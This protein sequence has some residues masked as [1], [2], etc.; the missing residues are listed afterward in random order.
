MV[1]KGVV[2]KNMKAT[3]DDFTKTQ[4]EEEDKVK[5]TVAQ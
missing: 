3:Y 2:Q 4:S 1:S 5:C